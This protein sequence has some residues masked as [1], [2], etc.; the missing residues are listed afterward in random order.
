MV[1]LLNSSII[2]QNIK[3]IRSNQENKTQEEFAEMLEITAAAVSKIERGITIPTT[4]TLANIAKCCNTSIDS[5]LG[6]NSK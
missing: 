2:G 5:I 4:Q 1:V 6:I 3:N